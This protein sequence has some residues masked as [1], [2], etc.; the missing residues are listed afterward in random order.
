[1]S[2]MP[3]LF[4]VDFHFPK[5]PESFFPVIIGW[6][7]TCFAEAAG[8]YVSEMARALE[9]L[10]LGACL[11]ASIMDCV[12]M[13]Y[14]QI[15]VLDCI[16]VARGKEASLLRISTRCWRQILQIIGGEKC[17]ISSGPSARMLSCSRLHYHRFKAYTI[18][19]TSQNSKRSRPL[20]P[21]LRAPFL[22]QHLDSIGTE[23][24]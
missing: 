19:V 10:G 2:D 13:G 8:Q 14:P 3:E 7:V 20:S 1:M 24:L 6:Q 11:T 23:P 5:I 21:A 4:A 17:Q 9:L 16:Q 18:K 12:V 15:G 22:L